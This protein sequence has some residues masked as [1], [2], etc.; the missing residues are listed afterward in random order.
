MHYF[1]GVSDVVKTFQAISN[2][3]GD[4][5]NAQVATNQNAYNSHTNKHTHIRTYRCYSN[6]DLLPLVTVFLNCSFFG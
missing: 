4:V 6:L 1:L 5:I 2:L 3:N